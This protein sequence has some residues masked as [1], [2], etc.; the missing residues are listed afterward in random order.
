MF[1]NKNKK[2]NNS[3]KTLLEHKKR[4]DAIIEEMLQRFRT[5]NMDCDGKTIGEVYGEEARKVFE[6]LFDNDNTA[7]FYVLAAKTTMLRM[8]DRVDFASE[9]YFKLMRDAGLTPRP[10]PEYIFNSAFPFGIA[11][12]GDYTNFHLIGRVKAANI[13]DY[14]MNVKVN[15]FTNLYITYNI[16]KYGSTKADGVFSLM[17]IV[18]DIDCHNMPKNM[19]KEDFRAV[20]YK[21]RDALLRFF[22]AELGPN[23]INCSGRGLQMVFRVQKCSFKLLWVMQKLN[24]LIDEMLTKFFAENEEFNMFSLDNSNNS[25]MHFYRLPFTYNIAGQT[26][27]DIKVVRENVMDVNVMLRAFY[28]ALNGV[29]MTEPNRATRRENE[30]QTMKVLKAEVR[31]EEKVKKVLAKANKT[32]NIQKSDRERNAQ[33]GYANLLDWRCSLIE[34]VVSRMPSHVGFRNKFIYNY[35]YAAIQCHKFETA[36]EMVYKLNEQF[37]EPQNISEVRSVCAALKRDS[38]FNI[39]ADYQEMKKH[40]QDTWLSFFDNIPN[41]DDYLDDF[42]AMKEKRQVNKKNNKR[43]AASIEKLN[44]KADRDEQIREL[45]AAGYLKKEIAEIVG[46]CRKTVYNVLNKVRAYTDKISTMISGASGL[47][48]API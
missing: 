27:G 7:G 11:T 30:Q 35:L 43:I 32:K 8:S 34:Y 47:V 44:K 46:V 33:R 4:E 42:R 12:L 28:K 25:P 48:T 39:T 20:C 26:W 40:K 45:S 10:Y 22:P 13:V 2:N 1:W 36:E 3:P 21:L 15:E 31:K 16:S 41:F 14:L 9:E 24:A 29:E 17:S 19:T 38:L 6:L 37:S 18:K 23:T 5:Y